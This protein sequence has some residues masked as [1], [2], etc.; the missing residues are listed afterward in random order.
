MGVYVGNLK[1]GTTTSDL[2]DFFEEDDS[3]TEI[4]I[5]KR[6]TPN[7]E[8]RYGHVLFGSD[9]EAERAIRRRQRKE[10]Y[11]S[12]VSVRKFIDRSEGN[13]RRT[14]DWQHVTWPRPERRVQERRSS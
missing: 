7:G 9:T 10:L 13:D 12:T 5:V 4:A 11:G 2:L 1:P 14:P 8:V 6:P 3:I